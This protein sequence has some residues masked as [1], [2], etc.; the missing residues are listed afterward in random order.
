MHF[1]K[2]CVLP[3]PCLVIEFLYYVASY[4]V[5]YGMEIYK[6]RISIQM[7]RAHLIETKRLSNT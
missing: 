3:S 5:L 7:F 2:G 1:L 6:H 4:I